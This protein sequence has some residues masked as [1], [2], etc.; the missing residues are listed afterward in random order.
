MFKFIFIKFVIK[1]MKK[2]ILLFILGISTFIIHSQETHEQK[3]ATIIY[4]FCRLVQWPDYPNNTIQINVYRESSVTD[5][6][7]YLSKKNQ[8][9][10]SVV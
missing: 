1:K 10:K 3:I 6:I 9:R 4:G 2:I 8:D 7:N 5:Y